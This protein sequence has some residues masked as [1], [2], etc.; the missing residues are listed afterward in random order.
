[1]YLLSC[2]LL[3]LTVCDAETKACFCYGIV[4]VKVD[5]PCVTATEPSARAVCATV[6]TDQ[7][8]GGIGP[9]PD[10]NSVIPTGGMGLQR[11]S[12]ERELH[13]LKNQKVSVSEKRDINIFYI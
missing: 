13:T 4:G 1:M 10:L 3:R 7:G 8:T 2:I 6:G 5:G 11:K 12:R 9:I